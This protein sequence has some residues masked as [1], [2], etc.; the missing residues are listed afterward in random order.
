MNKSEYLHVL[1]KELGFKN[2]IEKK[3]IIADYDE[4]FRMGV[5]EGKTE[6]QIA[7]GLGDPRAIAKQFSADYLVRQAEHT[8]SLGNIVRA[9]IAT[10]GLGFFNLIFILGPFLAV[11]GILVGLFAA[12]IGMTLGGL[13]GFVAAVLQVPF[14]IT[15]HPGAA[16][17]LMIGL[18]ASG[19][20]LFI[21]NC[22]IGKF[23]YST[24]I[25]YLK[26]NVSIIRK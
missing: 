4:H 26:I 10:V 24:M 3:E 9:V 17:F 8:K 5:L 11:A 18:T 23:V 12:S 25:A 15:I 7:E 6:E 2:T 16:I 22:Y 13:A 21:G 14:A 20:L 1:G 19:L